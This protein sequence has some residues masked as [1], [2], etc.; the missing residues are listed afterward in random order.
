VGFHIDKVFCSSPKELP[1]FFRR[2]DLCSLEGITNG[3]WISIYGRCGDR[4]FYVPVFGPLVS[5]AMQLAKAL[6]TLFTLSFDAIKCNITHKDFCMRSVQIIRHTS[7]FFLHILRVIPFFGA[8]I[9]GG[10]LVSMLQCTSKYVAYN[11]T[12]HYNSES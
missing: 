1:F 7:S 8:Y 9:Y 6:Y 4:V 11:G 5:S 10:L 3:F 12:R 2:M